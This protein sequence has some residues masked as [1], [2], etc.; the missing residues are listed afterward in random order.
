MTKSS[1]AMIEATATTNIYNHSTSTILTCIYLTNM[2][3]DSLLDTLTFADIPSHTVLT[4]NLQD[5]LIKKSAFAT[6]AFIYH[7]DDI[8]DAIDMVLRRIRDKENK[9]I[10]SIESK[11]YLSILLISFFL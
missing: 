10:A 2:T 6:S 5:G 3:K 11:N 7:F 8:R 4:S 1:D 9:H